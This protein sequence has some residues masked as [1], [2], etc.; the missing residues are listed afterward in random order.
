MSVFFLLYF[1]TIRTIT[2]SN[3]SDLKLYSEL[4]CAF[5]ISTQS[6]KK[7]LRKICRRFSNKYKV[8]WILKAL[9]PWCRLSHFF[10]QVTVKIP[11]D[12]WL[13]IVKRNGK[14]STKLRARLQAVN[15]RFSKKQHK[16]N[17]T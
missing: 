16:N 1:N 8:V 5:Q 7:L 15:W 10:Y 4:S 9:G 3:I 14:K 13:L 12:D 17:E 11:V 6:V 2:I